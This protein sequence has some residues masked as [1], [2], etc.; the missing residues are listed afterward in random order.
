MRTIVLITVGVAIAVLLVLG[1][2][3]KPETPAPPQQ[4]IPQPA[5]KLSGLPIEMT[6]KQRTTTVLPG[7]GGAVSVTIDD[8]T[9]GQVMVSLA[10]K[11]GAVLLGPTS[12][13][14]GKSAEFKLGDESY[15]V[16]LEALDNELVGEDSATLV[17]SDTLP[18]DEAPP[19]VTASEAEQEPDA[20]LEAAKIEQLIE[21]VGSLEGAVFIRNGEEHTPTE[22]AA[23]LRRKWEAA[24]GRITSAQQF[25]EQLAS[26]SSVSGETYRI[27]LADGT[28]TTSGEYLRTRLA[29]MDEQP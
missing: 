4:P 23:H 21:H 11:D 3:T 15:F 19:K 6:V 12:L 9:R 2:P 7:S 8:I 5:P 20:E 28:E 13:T 26:K 29:E 22:A 24:G 18:T 14:A 10:A 16:L 27:R 1:C 25:I 17:F